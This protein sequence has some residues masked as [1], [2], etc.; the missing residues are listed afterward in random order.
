MKLGLAAFSIAL[1]M[2]TSAM[3]D[4]W[5][6]YSN[7][8]TGFTIELPLSRFTVAEE[9]SARL[10]LD[11]INGDVQLDVF[12]V[13]NPQQ[14]STAQFQAMMEAADPNRDI[15]Y[16]AAG[17]SWFVLSGYLEDRSEPTVF[18][19]K[20]MLNRTGTALSAFE[21]SYPAKRKAEMDRVVERIENSMTAPR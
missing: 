8:V 14:L 3:A 5:Q 4:A 1:V 18:Y 2:A 16:R 20:F 19:A 6:R 21:I 9:T 15:T 12:G 11:E 10:A 17:R 7:T 13:T